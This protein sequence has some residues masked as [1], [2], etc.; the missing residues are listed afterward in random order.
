MK[1]WMFLFAALA[2]CAA[3]FG[4]L[5]YSDLNEGAQLDTIYYYN[6]KT[7][8]EGEFKAALAFKFKDVADEYYHTQ[9]GN[10]LMLEFYDA[11][12]VNKPMPRISEPFMNFKVSTRKDNIQLQEDLKPKIRPIVRFEFD[13]EKDV[14]FHYSVEGGQRLITL[15]INWSKS[16]MTSEQRREIRRKVIK[17]SL[18]TV[19]VAGLVGGVVWLVKN[20]PEDQDNS[21]LYAKQ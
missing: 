6:V 1:K 4:Q 3:A 15:T 8:N 10:H 18:T 11:G 21:G 2:C 7:E 5:D 20:G 19:I 9:K 17:Y 14:Q 13:L 16:G 12:I